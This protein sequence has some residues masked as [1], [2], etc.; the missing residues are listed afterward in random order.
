MVFHINY[1]NQ[2]KFIKPKKEEKKTE[3]LIKWIDYGNSCNHRKLLLSMTRQLLRNKSYEKKEQTFNNYIEWANQTFSR[4]PRETCINNTIM[5]T[6]RY[7]EDNE[8]IER[9]TKRKNEKK[10]KSM[11]MSSSK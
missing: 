9:K 10:N 6:I 4:R 2:S 3:A 11:I 7:D 5:T 8:K 1:M